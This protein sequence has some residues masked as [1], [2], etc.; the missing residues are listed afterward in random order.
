MTNTNTVLD[1][2]QIKAV[3]RLLSCVVKPGLINLDPAEIQEF[4][5]HGKS[6]IYK[7]ATLKYATKEE[8]EKSG[9]LC[10]EL[11]NAHK[12]LINIESGNNMT[13]KDIDN[14]AT[15]IHEFEDRSYCMFTSTFDEYKTDEFLVELFILQ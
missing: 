7:S 14:I 3:E 6:L 1:L 9:L 2:K 8:I 10:V 12:Y 11:H 4:L 15:A 5:K 13:L